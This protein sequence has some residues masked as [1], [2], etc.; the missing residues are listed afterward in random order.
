ML[1]LQYRGMTYSRNDAP[2]EQLHYD[3]TTFETRQNHASAVHQLTYR[4]RS[5][6]VD[7]S[8]SGRSH[9]QYCYRGV[10]YSR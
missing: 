5:Y 10:A 1:T 9:D 7:N 2:V 4:G 3:R 8:L 6:T